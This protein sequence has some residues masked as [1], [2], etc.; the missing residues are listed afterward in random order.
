[1]TTGTD[2]E[3]DSRYEGIL[4]LVLGYCDTVS[5]EGCLLPLESLFNH[6]ISG[7]V[8]SSATPYLS[9]SPCLPGLYPPFQHTVGNRTLR[10]SEKLRL[11]VVSHGF[12]ST[13]ERRN[14]IIREGNCT[15]YCSVR[16]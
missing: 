15:I 16:L 6:Y 11:E 2:D 12:S 14:D 8:T 7:L 13:I 1:M 5:M 10:M 9:P 3:R 4:K